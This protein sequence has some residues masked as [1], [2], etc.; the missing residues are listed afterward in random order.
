METRFYYIRLHPWD[1]KADKE[2]IATWHPCTKARAEKRQKAAFDTESFSN[3][4]V[5]LTETF[6]TE[7]KEGFVTI[8]ELELENGDFESALS[9]TLIKEW[10]FGDEDKEYRAQIALDIFERAADCRVAWSLRQ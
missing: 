5:S 3:F 6:E 7:P 4:V 1:M 8:R 2:G 10:L 9:I